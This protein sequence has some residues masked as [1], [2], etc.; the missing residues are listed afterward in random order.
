MVYGTLPGTI[1]YAA[2]PV[3]GLNGVGLLNCQYTVGEICAIRHDEKNNSRINKN[4][5]RM[6]ECFAKDKKIN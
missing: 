2:P 5:F 6:I 1:V 3:V 4:I